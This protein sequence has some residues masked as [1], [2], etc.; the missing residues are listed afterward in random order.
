VPSRAF[1]GLGDAKT[2]IQGSRGEGH[3]VGRWKNGGN[4]LLSLTHRNPF[5]NPD[6]RF[7][8]RIC[9]NLPS[10]QAS[11]SARVGRRRRR[12][13]RMPPG[14]GRSFDA[15]RLTAHLTSRH[16]MPGRRGSASG[17]T[18]SAHRSAS[19]LLLLV[20]PSVPCFTPS[21]SST[22]PI[23]RCCPYCDLKPRY[24]YAPGTALD[25]VTMSAIR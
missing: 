17:C 21:I 3:K 14:V 13:R 23:L 5:A 15:S 25:P 12:C 2:A 22:G 11:V 18:M 7:P 9:F 20:S 16:A 10:G 19:P 6:H 4:R 1:P 8:L 24:R